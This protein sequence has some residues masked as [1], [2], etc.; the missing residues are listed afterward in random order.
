M[1]MDQETEQRR[2]VLML[3][4]QEVEQEK[5]EVLMITD[6]NDYEDPEFD[7][8]TPPLNKFELT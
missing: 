5:E 2:E 3:M 8:G 1:F 6:G 7:M 4:N